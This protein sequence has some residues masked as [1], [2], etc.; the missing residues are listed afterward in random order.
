MSNLVEIQLTRDELATLYY[1]VTLESVCELAEVKAVR[2]IIED[3]IFEDN[4]TP[5]SGPNGDYIVGTVK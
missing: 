3:A 1:L 4:I 2:D 5:E